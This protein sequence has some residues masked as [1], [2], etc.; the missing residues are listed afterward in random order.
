MAV[1][2]LAVGEGLGCNMTFNLDKAY[3]WAINTCNAPN[4]GYSQTYRNRRTVN[5]ITYYDCSSFI[6]YSI[7]AGGLVTSSYAPEHNPFTTY[8]MGKELKRLG[9]TEYDST[10]AGFIWKPGD[11]GVGSGHTEMCYGGGVGKA[12]FMGA[13]TSN[14]KLANQVSIG[15][16]GGNV[17]YR[18]TFS[19]CYRWK[20]DG[21]TKVENFSAYVVAAMCGNFWIESN[22]NPGVWENLK[23]GNWTDLMKGYGL[24]QWTNTNGDTHGRLYQLHKFLSENGYADY[25]MEGQLD[26][27]KTESVWHKGTD[28]QKEIPYNTLDEFLNSSSRDLNELTKA[29]FYC[30]EGIKN[31]TLSDRQNK[32]KI[33]YDY[34]VAHANDSRITT[35]KHS[36]DYLSMSDILNNAVMVYR[37]MGGTSG[38]ISGDIGTNTKAKR[39]MPIWMMVRYR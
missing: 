3:T 37:L 39:Q 28:Y 29:Y 33:C 17:T 1:L 11:I 16:S 6:N 35:Y 32:A 19:K 5:G 12:V 31:D 18:R 15:S 30:W 8:S 14:A 36:N 26:F 9:F 4:V 25:D 7:I 24:G 27:L 38:D 10:G 21:A 2:A 13:H 34:I 23:P 20:E 22:I